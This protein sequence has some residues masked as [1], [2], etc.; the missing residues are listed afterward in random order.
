MFLRV[1]SSVR[2]EHSLSRK[3]ILLARDVSVF[4][5]VWQAPLYR[6]QKCISC[7]VSIPLLRDRNVSRVGDSRRLVEN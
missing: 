6:Q 5:R 4:P 2:V 1:T 7:R 3:M